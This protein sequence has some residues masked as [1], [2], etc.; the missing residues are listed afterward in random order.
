MPTCNRP[1]KE[2]YSSLEG[3]FLYDLYELVEGRRRIVYV[4]EHHKNTVKVYLHR[5]VTTADMLHGCTIQD[6]ICMSYFQKVHDTTW[7][8]HK[9]NSIHSQRNININIYMY[10]CLCFYIKQGQ[11]GSIHGVWR[12]SQ[13]KSSAGKMVLHRWKIHHWEKKQVQYSPFLPDP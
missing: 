8:K 5:F 7:P 6:A 10:R 13:N 1:D 2:N 3:T 4:K 9:L 12:E 11:S